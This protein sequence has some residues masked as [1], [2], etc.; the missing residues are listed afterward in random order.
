MSLSFTWC[1]VIYFILKLLFSIKYIYIIK[2]EIESF[3]IHLADICRTKNNKN[4]IYKRIYEENKLDFN[5]VLYAF[6]FLLSFRFPIDEYEL[7]IRF[8]DLHCEK[9][10]L[11]SISEIK[12]LHLLEEKNLISFVEE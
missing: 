12:K 4:K 8:L 10:D 6:D 2:N 9:I 11:L 1:F 3:N 7:K 5:S